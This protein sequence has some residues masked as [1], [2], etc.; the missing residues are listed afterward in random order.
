M[1]SE[2]ERC[3]SQMGPIS[4]AMNGLMVIHW[5]FTMVQEAPDSQGTLHASGQHGSVHLS[6]LGKPEHKHGNQ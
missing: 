6:A 5:E 1:F 3:K 2:K 4:M